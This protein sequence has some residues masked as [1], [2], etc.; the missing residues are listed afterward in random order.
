MYQLISICQLDWDI[1]LGVGADLGVGCCL[2][3][4]YYKKPMAQFVAKLLLPAN[5]INDHLRLQVGI[6]QLLNGQ[7]VL[8]EF[9][10]CFKG[11]GQYNVAYDRILVIDGGIKFL[12]LF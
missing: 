1:C 12:G 8:L 2:R 3:Q 9:T 11:A 5:M 10:P 4:L 6:C 7:I